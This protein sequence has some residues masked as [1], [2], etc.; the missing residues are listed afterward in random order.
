MERN[1]ISS[2]N[3][4]PLIGRKPEDILPWLQEL[5]IYLV[6]VYARIVLPFETPTRENVRSRNGLLKRVVF[7]K[8]LGTKVI[9]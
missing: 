9:L 5:F 4:A 3:S 2:L 1:F 8:Q 6:C 7:A